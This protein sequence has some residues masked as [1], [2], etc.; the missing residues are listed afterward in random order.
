MNKEKKGRNHDSEH[1]SS[2]PSTRAL[3]TNSSHAEHMAFLQEASDHFAN[4]FGMQHREVVQ[5]VEAVYAE[6]RCW[7]MCTSENEK[8]PSPSVRGS[9][10]MSN[11]PEKT[12]LKGAAARTALAEISSATFVRAKSSVRQPMAKI[13]LCNINQNPE[14]RYAR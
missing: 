6:E 7:A 13:Q 10:S 8:E 4:T 2:V 11:A 5:S 1:F 9:D 14:K 3:H 12:S